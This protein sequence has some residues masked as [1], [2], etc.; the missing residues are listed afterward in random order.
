MTIFL[1]S[2]YEK[3]NTTKLIQIQHE[4][5]NDIHE[6]SYTNLRSITLE[7][8]AATTSRKRFLLI[9]DNTNSQR[10]SYIHIVYRY[11]A[12]YFLIVLVSCSFVSKFCSDTRKD[13][14]QKQARS[15]SETMNLDHV[16]AFAVSSVASRAVFARVCIHRECLE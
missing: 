6:Y 9:R 10:Q 16:K 3:L 13:R 2:I 4:Y 12:R 5:A 14:T 7:L 15:R 8:L 1:L 11:I